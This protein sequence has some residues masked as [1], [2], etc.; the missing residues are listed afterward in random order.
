MAG[1][2]FLCNRET[3]QMIVRMGLLHGR[4]DEV[5][6]LRR[7]DEVFLYNFETEELHGIYRATSAPGL[8]LD[9]EAFPKPSGGG[10]KYPAQVRFA[11]YRLCEPLP[12]AKF[13]HIP[14]LLHADCTRPPRFRLSLDAS[15]VRELRVLLLERPLTRDVTLEELPEHDACTTG[16]GPQGAPYSAD[17]RLL[18]IGDGDCSF[19][20]GLAEHWVPSR[21]PLLVVSTLDS[22]VDLLAKYSRAQ[23]ALE[24]LDVCGALTLHGVD[25]RA[26]GTGLE[27]AVE[28]LLA[29]KVPPPKRQQSAAQT[30]WASSDC[31]PTSCSNVFERVVAS[32]P[33]VLSGAHTRRNQASA[34]PHTPHSHTPPIHG[35]GKSP[36]FDRIVWNF[37]HAIGNEPRRA[38]T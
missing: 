19:A 2:L 12:L 20:M 11:V 18:L 29:P 5:R 22:H 3:Q 28:S 7:N 21:C 6:H 34:A 17:Q 16:W 32:L 8:D 35:A 38:P 15:Q 25:A 36:R 37:P 31:K 1:M 26:L 33:E 30:P 23:S 4:W 24:T 13:L 10:S 27:Q 9:P 14:T